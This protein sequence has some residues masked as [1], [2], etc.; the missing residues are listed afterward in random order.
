[1]SAAIAG[2]V[3]GL[4]LA[5]CLPWLPGALAVFAIA[6]A[7]AL[8]LLAPRAPARMAAGLLL[9]MALGIAHGAALNDRRLPRDCAR[10]LLTVEGEVASL[11]RVT[12]IGED[13]RQQRF[14]F[15][16][17]AISPAHCGGP[18]R[19]LLSYYGALSVAPGEHWV[20]EA[21]LR[22]PWGLVNPGSFN[23]Q[24]WF[25]QTGIDATGSARAQGALRLAP[26]AGPGSL[27]DRLR[28]QISQRIAA[29]PLSADAR[30]VLGAV[31]VADRSGLDTALWRLFQLYGLNHLL[32]ISGLHIGLVAALGYGLGRALA[33]ALAL[34]GSAA[35]ARHLPGLAALL[36][37]AVYTALAGFSLATVRALA[38]LACV[39]LASSCWRRAGSWHNLLLAAAVLLACNPLAGLGSGFWLSFG[40]VACLLWLA[41]WAGAAARWRQRLGTH[42]FMSV[43][44][45]PLC[46]WWFGGF[47]QVSAPA[48]ALLV[49]LLGLFVV[50][51]ALL[52]ALCALPGW[53]VA[54]TLWTWAAQPLELLLPLG[55]ALAADHP[56]WLFRGLAP[57]PLETGLALCAVALLVAPLD[58]RVRALLP[59]LLLPLLLPPATPRTAAPEA[60]HALVFDVGQGTAVLL[61]DRRRALLYDTGGGVAGGST[62]AR[63]VILPLLRQRGIARLDT[64]VVSHGDSDHSAG[65]ADILGALPVARLLVGAGVRVAAAGDQAVAR[66][67]AVAEPCRAGHHWRWPR[68][69]VHLR[70]LAPAPAERLSRNNGSCVL[71]V[72]VGGRRLLLPGDID[73]DRERALVRYW[74]GD[75]ASDW[76]LAAHHGSGSSSSHAWLKAVNPAEVVYSH[77]YANRFGHPHPAVVA[78]LEAAGARA[79]STASQGALE[80]VFHADGELQVI[81]HRQ[82]KRRYWL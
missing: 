40:A 8:L 58:W 35:D 63:S 2:A 33:M 41:M 47:S 62:I 19:A 78:R 61:Y 82:L 80:L 50:P 73:D 64:L 67:I 24:A 42:L 1:M 45:L 27:P 26:G 14:E 65:L 74:R 36:L 25:A 56:G 51:L 20:F 71:Q 43:A 15:T 49:P 70:V 29:L 81:A 37:A 31:T 68:G 59:A 6:V 12:H 72:S 17:A 16:V 77:G 54:D 32:V 9:G 53:P 28:A 39:V 48:N 60:I 5:A 52:G 66:D 57:G 13:T 22:R 38:M 3:A 23:M 44:M 55:R 18:R 79:W 4:L 11:P 69:D 34:A 75:L 10:E 21:R 46:G 30:A 7:G 76:L